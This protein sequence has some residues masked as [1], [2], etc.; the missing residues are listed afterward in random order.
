MKILRSS[1]KRAIYKQN[2][3]NEVNA[4]LFETA[5]QSLEPEVNI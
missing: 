4:T 5:E 3:N 1:I 2:S